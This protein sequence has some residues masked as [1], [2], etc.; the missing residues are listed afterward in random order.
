[1]R[2]FLIFA[3]SAT[4]AHATTYARMDFSLQ[5]AQGQ[6]IAGATVNVYTQAACGAASSGTLA[7]LYSTATG[8]SLSQPLSTDGFGHAYAY[9][10]SGCYTVVYYSQ[11][12][13]TL[14]YQDQVPQSTTNGTVSSPGLTSGVY[15]IAT[16]AQT[17]GN[18]TIDYGVTTAGQFTIPAPTV[19]D[20]A[21][22]WAGDLNLNFGGALPLD[23]TGFSNIDIGYATLESNTSGAYNVAIDVSALQANTGGS[24]N[25]AIG[26]GSLQEN[27][28][29]SDN[30]AIG[31][32]AAQT[33][34][35]GSDNVAIGT[36]AGKRDGLNHTVA[37]GYDADLSAS[38]SNEIV[39]GS[40]ATGHGSNTATIGDADVTTA[41]IGA[42]EI[43]LANGT[44]CGGDGGGTTTNALTF[45]TSGGAAPSGT[46]NGSAAVT[47]DYH[48]VGAQVNLSLV[49]GT[50]TDGDMC[51]Y[52]ASGTLLNCST[53][54]PSVGTNGSNAN[55]YWE[56]DEQGFIVQ[57]QNSFT[58][59]GDTAVTF[60]V[61]FTTVGTINIQMTAVMPSGDTGY[62]TVVAG[63]KTVSGFTIHPNNQSPINC[64]WNARGK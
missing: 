34:V 31:V 30:V 14:T 39:I 46:F 22:V 49:K 19:I 37:I 48:S 36:V 47:I 33:N 4:L 26:P 32:A 1:M 15:P 58:V 5:N 64:D 63:S 53:A 56:Q 50:L 18:G 3:L 57:W 24:E 55:G 11:Y 2:F 17:I 20:S 62:C 7:T 52:A 6:A 25:I 61:V 54:I 51:T 23:T 28:T 45:A 59:T 35:T 12:T 42:V 10:A 44:G 21:L 40:A 60:P 29:G 41:Y 27:T 9:M 16:G 8:T 38:D 13:G 43:C